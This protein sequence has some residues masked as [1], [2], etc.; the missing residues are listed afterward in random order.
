MQML[1]LTGHD[2]CAALLGICV[3]QRF[4]FNCCFGGQTR[5]QHSAGMLRNAAYPLRAQVRGVLVQHV[6]QHDRQRI[7]YQVQYHADLQAPQ[8]LQT[9]AGVHI[10]CTIVFPATSAAVLG[11]EKQQ[12]LL[13]MR[14][15]CH[16]ETWK[17][18][19]RLPAGYAPPPHRLQHCGRSTGG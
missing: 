11:V 6:V 19:L 10:C 4:F 16:P 9:A 14:C 5:E 7:L 8:R 13:L 17:A 3:W 1:L 12:G 15:S 18:V 2:E